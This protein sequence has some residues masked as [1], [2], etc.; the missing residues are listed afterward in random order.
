[1]RGLVRC[2]ACSSKSRHCETHLIISEAAVLEYTLLIL[3]RTLGW[4]AVCAAS[5]QRA[6][7]ANCW[8]ETNGEFSNKATRG[9]KAPS[10]TIMSWFFDIV[11]KF[12]IAIAASLPQCSSALFLASAKSA[13]SSGAPKTP[14]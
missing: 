8:H 3:K 12:P 14:T 5:R 6:L 4:L 9:S 10:S 7:H 11:A 1:V 2:E 13:E